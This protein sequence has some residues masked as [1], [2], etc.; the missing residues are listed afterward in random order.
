MTQ[1]LGYKVLLEIPKVK[2]KMEGMFYIAEDTKKK[3]QLG[4]EVGIVRALGTLAFSD[5]YDTPPVKIGDYVYF[6]RYAG[7][8]PISATKKNLRLIYDEDLDAIADKEDVAT[9]FE[10]FEK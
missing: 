6:R 9:E 10:L 1:P 7:Q 3:Q 4:A 5:K 8:Q 2:E